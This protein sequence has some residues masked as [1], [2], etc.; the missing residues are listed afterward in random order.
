MDCFVASLLAMT[1]EAIGNKLMS[2]S[3]KPAS[4][5]VTVKDAT[6]NLLRAFG[7]KKVFG[8]PG[9]TEL[10]FLAEWPDDIETLFHHKPLMERLLV[11]VGA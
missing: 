9:S 7:I 8:N 4:K 11:E 2:S 3:R 5:S 6:F 10:P 1:G